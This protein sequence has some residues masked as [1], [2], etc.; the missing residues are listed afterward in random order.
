MTASVESLPVPRSRPGALARAWAFVKRHALGVYSLLAFVYLLIPIAVVIV[1][2]FNNPK[3]RFNYTWQGFTLDNWRNWDAVPGLSDAMKLSL[4]IAFLSALLATALGT[5]IA[6]ALVRYLFR[7]RGPTNL[8]IFLPMSTPE[9]V[10]GASLLT[11]FLTLSV[12]QGFWTI[13]IAHIMFCIS[14][15]VVTVKARL[16]SFD[17][18]LEEAA[19]DLGANEWATFRK[20][21]LPLIAPAILAG[22]LLSFALSID[23]FTVTYFVA[24]PKITFP[25]FVWGA[26]RVGAPPQVNVIGTAIFI[27]ALA[28]MLANVLFQRRREQGAA[29][30]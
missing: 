12:V 2:S 5:A 15:V 26:A 17:R 25:L 21:T 16:I 8:V 9:I 18:H 24:G 4:E 10:L 19:M 7:G 11:L 29:A 1:F 20:V 14:Y 27:V 13:V 3:G 23:D 30:A 6:L 22:A 28:A